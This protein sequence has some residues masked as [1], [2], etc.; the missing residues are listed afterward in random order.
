LN[1]IKSPRGPARV[2]HDNPIEPFVDPPQGR[3][4][5]A[6]YLLHL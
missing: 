3:G 4:L 5:K 1:W 6:A 2:G